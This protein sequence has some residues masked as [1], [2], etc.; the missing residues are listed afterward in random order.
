MSSLNVSI[1]S[2]FIIVLVRSNFEFII[3]IK[4]MKMVRKGSVYFNVSLVLFYVLN[5][6]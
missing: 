3:I 6:N 2:I 1:S 5:S 4:M